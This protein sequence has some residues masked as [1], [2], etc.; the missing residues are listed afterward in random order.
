MEQSKKYQTNEEYNWIM[1]VSEP[2]QLR[3]AMH[4]IK[5][6]YI[7]KLVEAEL[8]EPSARHSCSL[9][10]SQ[11]KALTEHNQLTWINRRVK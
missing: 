4:E 1:E 10:V 5:Q 8:L 9:T 11:L 6:H 7:N 2:N 3:S